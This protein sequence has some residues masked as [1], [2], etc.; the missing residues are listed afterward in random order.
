MRP[1]LSP[2]FG[3]TLIELIVVVIVLGILMGI[4]IPSFLNASKGA[5]AAADK[6]NVVLAY[7][8]VKA[9]ATQLSNGDLAVLTPLQ[10]NKAMATEPEL[11]GT[12]AVAIAKDSGNLTFTSKDTKIVGTWHA[13]GTFTL[14][15]TS[16]PTPPSGDTPTAADT[17]VIFVNTGD[18][19]G[20]Y[21]S[22]LSRPVGGAIVVSDSDWDA[23]LAWTPSTDPYVLGSPSYFSTADGNGYG[24]NSVIYRQWQLNVALPTDGSDASLVS[25]L[26]AA[27]NSTDPASVGNVY[28]NYSV[29]PAGTSLGTHDLSEIAGGACG[30]VDPTTSNPQDCSGWLPRTLTVGLTSDPSLYLLD[31]NGNKPS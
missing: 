16:G 12:N 1:R 17:D 22:P 23:I 5:T 24:D 15:E 27:T 14:S 4:A 9:E 21:V 6:A 25:E 19:A 3:F 29:P 20:Y 8:A 11:T 10:L 30:T 7:K 13:N 2:R 28:G 31:G 18:F 26:A